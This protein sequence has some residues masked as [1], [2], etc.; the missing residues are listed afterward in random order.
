MPIANP[1][2]FT[3]AGRAELM[4]ALD[5]YESQVP[6]LGRDFGLAVAALIERVSSNP[7]QFPVVYKNIHRA[8]LRHFPYSLMFVIETDGALLAV[9]C[10]HASRDPAHWQERV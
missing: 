4:G 9:A 1:V 3:K 10:F 2:I 8:L 7:R 6:G 5:W